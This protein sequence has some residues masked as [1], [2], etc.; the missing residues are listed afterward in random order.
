L[1]DQLKAAFLNKQ[2]NLGRYERLKNRLNISTKCLVHHWS[3]AG[4]PGQ[5][6]G[7]ATHL[8]KVARLGKYL[9]RVGMLQL[10]SEVLRLA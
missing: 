4:G 3:K 6:A 9:K 7:Y 2:L 8:D 5:I 10:G 1:D